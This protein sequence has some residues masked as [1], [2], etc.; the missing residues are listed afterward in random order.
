LK[1][2]FE[3]LQ[4]HRILRKALAEAT[5]ETGLTEAGKLQ[6]TLHGVNRAALPKRYA[7]PLAAF[8]EALERHYPGMFHLEQQRQPEGKLSV[9]IIFHPEKAGGAISTLQRRVRDIKK[10]LEENKRRQRA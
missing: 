2:V 1:R 10:L 4:G 5:H 6:F 9:K 7:H 8:E 3:A